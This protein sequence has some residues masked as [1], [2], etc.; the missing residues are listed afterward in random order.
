[1][2][3][4][5][6]AALGVGGIVVLA[7]LVGA[8]VFVVSGSRLGVAFILSIP[9]VLLAAAGLWVRGVVTKNETTA[10]TY[11]SEKARKAGERLRDFWLTLDELQSRYPRWD[12]ESIEAEFQQIRTDLEDQGV[13]LDTDDGSYR[14]TTSGN[15]NIT[16]IE[17]CRSRL[18]ELAVKRDASFATFAAD[19][20]A[21]TGSELGRLGEFG[22][23]PPENWRGADAIDV[24][25]DPTPEHEQ[26]AQIL[27]EHRSIARDAVKR[28]IGV[29]QGTSKNA[30]EADE[31]RVSQ[32]LE[33]AQGALDRA[34]FGEAVDAVYDARSA[35]EADLADQINDDQER[36]L[37]LVDSVQ[38]SRVDEY[39]A[40]TH[41]DEVERIE[42]EVRAVDTALEMD[43][44]QRFRRELR[45]VCQEMVTNMEA[46]L[47]EALSTL[48]DAD[49][50]PDRPD[51]PAAAN[52][53]FA[54]QLEEIESI[55]TFRR[56]WMEAT[57]ELA[58]ALDDVGPKASVVEAY[59]DIEDRIAEVLERDGRVVGDELPVKQP[60]PF[61]KLY[62]DD[63]PTV[64]Y[65]PDGPVLTS[66]SGGE[67]Y[68]L[69]VTAKFDSGGDERPLSV[70]IEGD[71]VTRER[72]FQTPLG[73]EV[74][75]DDLPYGEYTVTA[76]GG[77][78]WGADEATVHLDG[79]TSVSLVV[80]EVTLREEV[81]D[82]VESDVESAF[83]TL[84][85]RLT[86]QFRTE[87]HLHSSMSFPVADR[88]VPCLLAIW[89]ED[90]NLTAQRSESGEVWVYDAGQG[91]NELRNVLQ[92]E[93]Q[94]GETLTFDQLRDRYLTAPLP[95]DLVRKLVND[96]D[97]PSNLNVT[98]TGLTL[99]E[100]TD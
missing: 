41:T 14:V 92:Y 86:E 42:R 91:Q 35:L 2:K 59:P 63:H 27:D 20:I 79:N 80:P 81:C 43:E 25:A 15:E 6:K 22:V 83:D 66:K 50:G 88:V 51:R 68:V 56:E 18:D 32:D 73:R 23:T 38:S 24:N 21:Q 40:P 57:G 97:Q 16:T 76:A 90:E 62:A 49:A 29:V 55:E 78:G 8:G 4:R 17:E 34:A 69:D 75:F 19:S 70:T 45:S 33:R 28:A 98:E 58:L 54:T 47:A 13:P 87:N 36:I 52:E 10:A 12:P 30:P 26:V 65:D 3:Q 60:A 7:V 77:D 72:S 11:I 74:Q 61:L 9:F 99:T 5:R 71:N 94:V 100:T 82:G 67:T 93:L 37:A 84:Q 95:D 48:R 46:D 64:R 44:L 31:K 85:S 53:D 96:L 39:V 89:A 1:M